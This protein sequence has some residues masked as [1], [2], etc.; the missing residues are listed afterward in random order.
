MSANDGAITCKPM[1]R[2]SSVPAGIEIAGMPVSGQTLLMIAAAAVCVVYVSVVF[3]ASED[4]SFMS[5]QPLVVD[6]GL[7]LRS[8]RMLGEE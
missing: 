2:P 4:A 1:G 8:S 3:L 7:W 5:G 6:G